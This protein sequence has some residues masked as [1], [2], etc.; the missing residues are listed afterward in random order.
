MNE[1]K[2]KCLNI[3]KEYIEFIEKESYYILENVNIEKEPVLAEE[4]MYRINQKAHELKKVI[5]IYCS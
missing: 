1:N 5:E 3:T 2:E 4:S